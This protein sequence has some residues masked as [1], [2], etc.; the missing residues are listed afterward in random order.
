MLRPDCERLLAKAANTLAGVVEKVEA[1][2]EA[3]EA[4]A[5]QAQQTQQGWSASGTSSVASGSRWAPP[6]LQRQQPAATAASRWASPNPRP[7]SVAQQRAAEASRVEQLASVLDLSQAAFL[8][9][10]Q[11]FEG[12]GERHA[13]AP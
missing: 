6:P 10:V 4:V 13:P 1:A 9:A 12:T 8:P 3:D 11:L 2:E 7:P 5:Q